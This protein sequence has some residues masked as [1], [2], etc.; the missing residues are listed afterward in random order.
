[1]GLVLDGLGVRSLRYLVPASRKGIKVGALHQERNATDKWGIMD[2]P[3]IC[4]IS[5]MLRVPFG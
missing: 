5:G 1:M 3:C 4:S 2:K